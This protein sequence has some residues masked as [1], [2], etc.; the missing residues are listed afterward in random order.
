M[1]NRIVFL[2]MRKV[3]LFALAGVALVG[4]A[5]MPKLFPVLKSKTSIG[6]QEGGFYLLPTNQ[7]LQPWGEQA[8][9]KGRPV[10]NATLDSSK[11]LLAVLN[12]RD[13]DIFDASTS[14]PL[15]TIR[16]R[17]TSY[18]GIAFRPGTREL[19]TG[20]TSRNGSDALTIV[21]VGT[22]GKAG[23]LRRV[24]LEGH[25]VPTGVAF[26]SDGKFAYVALSRNNSV[27]V[28]DASTKKLVREVPAGIAPFA[29]VYA[30]KV[31]K[32]FV[33]NRGGRRAT[34]KDTKAPTSGSDAVT[35]PVTGTTTTGTLTVIDAETFDTREIPVGLAPSGMALSAD[36]S[37]LAI[38]NGH[39][40][41]V[42]VLNTRTMKRDDVKIPSYP[43]GFIGSQPVAVAS[44]PMAGQSTRRAAASTRSRS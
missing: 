2:V 9:I 24:A 19:W 42:S 31:G 30:S 23:E 3:I 27:G 18:A 17:G 4:M 21:E 29:V 13:I 37:M 33:T 6:K 43:E 38:A 15:S 25:A 12:N 8:K 1:S 20:E 7:L 36:E 10:S 14:T 26:S 28:F 35:N 40:D 32:I 22:D 16:A 39:S 44:R 41:T 11:R 34:D 5:A